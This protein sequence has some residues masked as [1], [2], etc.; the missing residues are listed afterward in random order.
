MVKKIKKT[1]QKINLSR[2]SVLIIGFLVMAA[3]L[4]QRIFSLQII[5]GQEYADNFSL[6]TTSEP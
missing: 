4:L 3:I 5:H 1:F 6:Q 2:T